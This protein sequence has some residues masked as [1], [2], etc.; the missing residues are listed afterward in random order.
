LEENFRNESVLIHDYLG[1]DY[2]RVWM[3]IKNKL[4]ELK[5]K[6][7]NTLKEYGLMPDD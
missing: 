3:A 5:D 4:P 2:E 7:Q 6:I 1:V